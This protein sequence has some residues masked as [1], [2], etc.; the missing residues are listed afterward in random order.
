MHQ[1]SFL[2]LNVDDRQ[3]GKQTC[4]ESDNGRNDGVGS[5]GDGH[6]AKALSQRKKRRRKEKIENSN[7]SI[8]I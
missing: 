7:I 4:G 2:Y 8:I 3:G 6:G 5:D 1:F